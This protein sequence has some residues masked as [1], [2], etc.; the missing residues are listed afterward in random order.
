[1][2]KVFRQGTGEDCDRIFEIMVRA[3]K[4]DPSN[5]KYEKRRKDV[6][7]RPEAYRVLEIDERVVSIVRILRHPM[8]V[9]R[10]IVV[11]GD[12]GEVS[13]DPDCQ[14]RGLMTDL[15][16]DCVRWMREEGYHLSRLGGLVHF[17]SRFGY[18]P[19][20][21]RTIE[22]LLNPMRA[23]G[24]IQSPDTTLAAPAPS[25][26]IVRHY[27]PE[28]DAPWR[29]WL[30]WH[31]NRHRTGAPAPSGAEEPPLPKPL[32]RCEAETAEQLGT[33]PL[34]LVYQEGDRIY[35]CISA[36]ENPEYERYLQA[37]VEIGS[38]AFDL[39][40]PHAA[41][42]LVSRVLHSALWHGADRVVSR[43]P[44]DPAQY[45]AL[46]AG[47]IRFRT[48]ELHSAFA[49]NM[50]RV[51]D[52]PGLLQSIQPELETRL[53][54][55]GLAGWNGA[56]QIDVEGATTTVQVSDRGIAVTKTGRPDAQVVLSQAQFVRLLLGLHAAREMVPETDP[57]LLALLDILFP[58][59]AT[60]CGLWG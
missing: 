21:R 2:E 48:V 33:A 35:G 53:L 14:G 10:A 56:L 6:A 23:A 22:F 58:H 41:A 3:F 59:Q 45:D 18:T 57:E 17:Y 43:L 47:K 36:H 46:I 52:L 4:I 60:A 32:P 29:A 39:S 9:G 5:P 11:K 26:G 51:V 25:P 40:H 50:I 7:D 55:S 38:A 49:S 54:A 8:Q 37:K 31:F 13:T 19:F 16:N 1:L 27:R 44:F 28:T 15:M 34:E 12:V 20:P 30:S 24:G 42:A